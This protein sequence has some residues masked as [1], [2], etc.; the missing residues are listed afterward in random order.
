MTGIIEENVVAEENTVGL[1]DEEIKQAYFE[2]I[3]DY[4]NNYDLNISSLKGGIKLALSELVK[5]DPMSFSVTSEK[6]SDLS[7]TFANDGGIPKH[8]IN[9]LTPYK[10]IKSL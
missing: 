4:C 9:Y 2:Y 1:T 7:Q 5:T 3:Q 6:L 8:I 10:R